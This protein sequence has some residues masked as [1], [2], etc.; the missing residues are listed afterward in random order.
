MRIGIDLGGTKIEGIILSPDGII[1][2]K[3]RIDTPSD[4]YKEIKTNS[5]G[6]YKEKGSKFISYAYPVYSEKEIK[7][8]IK[9]NLLQP[10]WENYIL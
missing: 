2:K 6:L 4:T 10:T 7:V 1:E 8:L 5:K 3:I 9:E